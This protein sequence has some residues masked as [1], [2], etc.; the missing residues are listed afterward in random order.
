[1][2]VAKIPQPWASLLMTEAV[3]YIL[4]LE[5]DVAPGEVILIYATEKDE[6]YSLDNEK[7][8]VDDLWYNESVMGNLDDE[9]ET[10]HFLG[11]VKALNVFPRIQNKIYVG[12]VHCFEKPLYSKNSRPSADILKTPC[13]KKNYEII[14][15]R[16]IRKGSNE[17]VVPLGKEA[18]KNLILKEEDINLYWSE[19][20]SKLTDWIVSFKDEHGF[21]D[22]QF[23]VIFTHDGGKVVWTMLNEDIYKSFVP[24]YETNEK[25]G[26]K[27]N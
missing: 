15:F 12:D 1:M 5:D 6:R 4:P 9:L 19:E 10:A 13:K 24:I 25:T 20:F 14:T 3:E 2:K 18:W 16:T 21:W 22:E 8:K 17:I 26:K 7:M 23:E 27:H 11:Y